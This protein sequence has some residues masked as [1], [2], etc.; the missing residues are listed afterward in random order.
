VEKLKNFVTGDK[1]TY[2]ER[3]LPDVVV[4]KMQ[5]LVV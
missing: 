1:K 3:N 5:A 4:T 2:G